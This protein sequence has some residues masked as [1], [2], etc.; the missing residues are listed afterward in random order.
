MA[1]N[2]MCGNYAFHCIKKNAKSWAWWHMLIISATWERIK[3][4]EIQG[5]PKQKVSKIPISTS[6]LTMVVHTY[7]LLSGLA[8]RKNCKTLSEN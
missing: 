3:K 6:K 5:Q 7:Y 2:S 4:I 8:L 1:P